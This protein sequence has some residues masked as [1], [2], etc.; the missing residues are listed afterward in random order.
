L[1]LLKEPDHGYSL[2]KKL[3]EIKK[4]K[5]TP[6]TLYP[7]LNKLEKMKLIKSK[8][9]ERKKVYSLTDE[10]RKIMDRSCREFCHTFSQIFHDF[11]CKRCQK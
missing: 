11:I 4:T 5:I 8:K 1:W 7:V 6:S 9:M 10:G 2:I 3:N